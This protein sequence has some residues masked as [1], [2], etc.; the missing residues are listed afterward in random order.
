M[1][2]L[3]GR[4][5]SH[6]SNTTPEAELISRAAAGDA[7]AFGIIMQQHNQLLFRTA[8]SVV[9]NDSEAEDVAQE[10]KQPRVG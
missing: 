7:A 2:S 10:R 9:R 8:R 5:R 6:P 1:Q 3:Q 4:T